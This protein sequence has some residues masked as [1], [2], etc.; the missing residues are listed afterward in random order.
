MINQGEDQ[1]NRR[2]SLPL[3]IISLLYNKNVA[4]TKKNILITLKCG[5]FFRMMREH[6]NDEWELFHP[7][8]NVMWLHYLLDKLTKEVSYKNKKSKM[9]Q[10]AIKKMRQV[11]N[12]IL[13]FNSAYDYITST[14]NS[15]SI[16]GSTT[17]ID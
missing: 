1:I 11:M 15:V 3:L 5:V 16:K 12:G 8:T 4:H 6:T 10:N 7:K 14:S 2:K 13:N 17:S 9:H